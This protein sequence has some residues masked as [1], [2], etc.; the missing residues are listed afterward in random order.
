MR[1]SLK[2]GARMRLAAI[3]AV[4]LATLLGQSRQAD[5]ALLI[6]VDKSQQEMTVTQDGVPKY[7]W[8]VSTGVVGHATPAGDYTPFRMEEDHFSKEWDDAPMP[9]SIFFTRQ[10]HAIHG[11]SHTKN[12]GSP[13]SHGCVRLLPA[14]AAILFAMVKAEGLN[15]TKV[16]I[17]GDE[18]PVVATRK[19]TRAAAARAKQDAETEA[20]PPPPRVTARRDLGATPGYE[21]NEGYASPRGRAIYGEPDPVD[22]YAQRMR[23]RYEAERTARDAN[24][25]DTRARYQPR[26]E[27]ADSYDRPRYVSPYARSY[28]SYGYWD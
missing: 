18:P 21:G 14:N 27:A 1:A 10:G 3:S 23:R 19:P 2:S 20:L 16:V 5:A 17:K 8:P 11:S 9:H 28:R 6:T 25:F 24:E 13:A 22:A 26:Y 15:K 4:M 12:L 7:V